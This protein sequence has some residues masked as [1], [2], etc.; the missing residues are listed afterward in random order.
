MALLELKKQLEKGNKN[1]VALKINDNR[2]TMLSVRWDPKEKYTRVSLHRIFLE[3]PRN[4]MEKLACYVRQEHPDISREV[5]E[6]IETQLQLLDYSDKIDT[7]Q[8]YTQGNVYNLQK[9]Y[10]ELN[11]HYFG[12]K[13][14]LRVTWYGRPSRKSRNHVT[15]GLY[16]NSLKLIKIHRLLDSP[17]IPDYVVQYVVYHE[18]VHHICPSYFDAKGNHQIHSKEF[19]EQEEKFVYYQLAQLWIKTHTD[20][21]F[22]NI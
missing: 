21:L 19:K 17:F 4:I 20:Y 1:R 16:H 22:S 7:R 8:L 11:R 15:F 3:A 2:S 14:H 9:I 18:M 10:D 12:G 6:Y 13:L 5:K